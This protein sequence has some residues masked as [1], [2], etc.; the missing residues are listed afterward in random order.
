MSITTKCQHCGHAYIV[1]DEMAGRRVRCRQCG[2][3]FALPALNSPPVLGESDL[4]FPGQDSLSSA[5]LSGDTTSVGMP[6]PFGKRDLSDTR[7]MPAVSMSE[8]NMA[9]GV[10]SAKSKMQRPDYDPGEFSVAGDGLLDTA[11][12]PAVPFDFPFARELDAYLPWA[13]MGLLTLLWGWIAYDWRPFRAMS[14]VTVDIPKLPTWSGFLPLGVL[15]LGFFAIWVPIVGSASKRAAKAA[16]IMLPGNLTRRLIAMA[17]APFALGVVFWLGAESVAAGVT[18]A[19]LGLGVMFLAAWFLLRLQ[20]RDMAAFAIALGV[21]GAVAIPLTVALVLGANY[22]TAQ[23]VLALHRQDEFSVSPMGPGLA[24]DMTR[25][26]TR[27]VPGVAMPRNAGEK[28][29]TGQPGIT[30]T[31]GAGVNASP[32]ASQGSVAVPT[33]NPVRPVTPTPPSLANDSRVAPT[34]TPASP[35]S[36]T[37]V[38]TVTPE[39][40]LASYA[41]NPAVGDAQLLPIKDVRTLVYP[42]AQ[43]VGHFVA[44]SPDP[45]VNEDVM[46]LFDASPMAS[47]GK[48][49]MARE[50]NAS[51]ALS[52][53]GDLFA[54]ITRRPVYEI[55]ARSF[56]KGTV[57]RKQIVDRAVQTRILGFVSDSIF[58]VESRKF[59][60]TLE[61]I[62]A[63]TQKQIA[64]W[65][66]SIL[67]RSRTVA[68]Y[69]DPKKP[70]MSRVALVVRPAMAVQNPVLM[71]VTPSLRTAKPVTVD[72]GAVEE[73]VVMN[74]TGI[75]FSADGRQVALAYESSGQVRV[76]VANLEKRSFNCY[77]FGLPVN[78]PATPVAMGAMTPGVGMSDMSVEPA[79][80]NHLSWVGADRWLYAGRLL[81]DG[82]SQSV[83]AVMGDGCR[84]VEQQLIDKDRVQLLLNAG[85]PEA[86]VVD[87]TLRPDAK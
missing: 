21:G 31:P 37:P 84:S 52:P 8:S 65:N 32:A 54:R 28:P 55:E 76:M 75:A 7:P 61:L 82:G 5:D 57:M 56:T 79:P 29:A 69:A 3:T 67:I 85:Q 41:A 72:L 68:V 45:T 23:T 25:S 15:M 77:S 22:A 35:S 51:M 80:A 74:P 33:A 12:R 47:V 4:A 71:V 40:L 24:W 83:V 43:P 70:E 30:P 42:L 9:G 66:D 50:A 78:F 1:K 81:L 2:L 13:M 26:I 87:V 63:L 14:D 53:D 18:G 20:H 17:C 64:V 59:G 39:A 19:V 49:Q 27:S 62:D 34:A 48:M 73:S 46:E 44:V 58:V 86:C 60:Y 36:G 38:S 10:G 11:F 16:R 6:T